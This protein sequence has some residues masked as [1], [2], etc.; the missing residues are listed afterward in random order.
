MFLAA[1]ADEPELA[2]L[3]LSYGAAVDVK[4]Q[5]GWTPLMIAAHKGHRELVEILVTEGGADLRVEDKF[6]KKAHDRAATS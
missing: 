4:D 5:R 6:G 3:L 1:W 2:R